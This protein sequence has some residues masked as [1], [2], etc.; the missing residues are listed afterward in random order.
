MGILTKLSKVMGKQQFRNVCEGMFTSKLIYCI[1]LFGN[2]WGI[3]NLDMNNRR[4]VAFT[5]DD[6]RKLQVLQNKVLQLKTDLARDTPTTHLLGWTGDMSV[7]QLTA[8]HTLNMVH[9]VV[10]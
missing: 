10:Y 1:Q 5:K 2:V 7:H 3:P 9:G 4:S 8:Y 6:N